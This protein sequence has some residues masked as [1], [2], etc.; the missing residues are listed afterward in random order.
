MA[1]VVPSLVNR[2]TFSPSGDTATSSILVSSVSMRLMSLKVLPS[3][4]EMARALSSPEVPA[5]TSEPAKAAT[6]K[7]SPPGRFVE[8][9]LLT[10]GD[11]ASGL[12]LRRTLVLS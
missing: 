9:A 5:T 3:S 8:V 12:S 7:L 6:V 11:D 1:V 4:L 10:D 2:K